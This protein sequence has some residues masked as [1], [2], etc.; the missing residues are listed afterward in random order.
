MASWRSADLKTSFVAPTLSLRFIQLA[1]LAVF[2]AVIVFNDFY[3][4]QYLMGAP[5]P[6]TGQDFIAFYAASALSLAGDPLAAYNELALHAMERQVMP[7]NKSIPW[8]YPPTFLLAVQPLALTDYVTSRVLFYGSGWLL[9]MAAAWCWLRKPTYLFAVGAA[10][11]VFASLTFGQNGLFTAAFA[12]FAIHF[13][14]Q[15]PWLSGFFIALLAIKPH[16]ALL[17]PLALLLGRHYRAFLSAT[18]FTSVFVIVATA[19][20]GI[21]AWQAF[22]EATEAAA[23][24]MESGRLALH[25]MTSVMANTLQLGMSAAIAYSAQALCALPFLAAFVMIWR[26]SCDLLLRGCALMLATLMTLPYVFD[27]DL[28]WHSAAL[29][30]LVLHSLRHGWL[31]GESIIYLFLW[32]LPWLELIGTM[33][34]STEWFPYNLWLPANSAMLFMLWRRHTMTLPT[35]ITTD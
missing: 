31:K 12:L 5:S 28:T 3:I 6:T 34:D 35:P 33:L 32:L 29:G 18:L 4:R 27:Y 19:T 16:L 20:F 1:S 21:E 17:F 30:M 24:H 9:F 14:K 15:R 25:V 2:V 22:L 7:D 23:T 11:P 8:F 26:N 13:L 10:A